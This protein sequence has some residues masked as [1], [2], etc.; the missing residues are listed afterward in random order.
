MCVPI[1]KVK[2]TLKREVVF[3]LLFQGVFSICETLSY[4]RSGQN[5]AFLAYRGLQEMQTGE[6]YY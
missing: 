3:Q 1:N 4:G 5:D 6:L 2:R